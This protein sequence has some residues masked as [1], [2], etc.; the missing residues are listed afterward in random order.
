MLTVKN[1]DML[2]G[3]VFVLVGVLGFVPNPLISENGFF[4]V[5]PA[6]NAVHLLSGLLLLYGAFTPALGK[7]MLRLV[8]VVYGIVA[9]WGF[10]MQG[11]MMLGMVHINQAD[12]WL[13]V[14]LAAVIC[15]L[16]FVTFRD[17]QVA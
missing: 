7:T 9:V 4:A 10:F 14:A 6:H 17:K 11:D 16:G 3:I 8:G 2:L 5:N 12:K 1:V 13:H 15:F